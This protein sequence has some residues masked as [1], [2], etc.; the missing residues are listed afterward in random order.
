MAQETWAVFKDVSKPR[1]SASQESGRWA[2]IS[3]RLCG[4]TG[5]SCP[6][7]CAKRKS[8]GSGSRN[9]LPEKTTKELSEQPGIRFG[10]IKPR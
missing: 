10:K 8:I 2:R 4:S 6:S 7:F 3:G 9:G 5:N 1:S